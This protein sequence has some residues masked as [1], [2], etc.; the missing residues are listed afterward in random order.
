MMVSDEFVPIHDTEKTRGYAGVNFPMQAELFSQYQNAP[1][2][3][4]LNK[5]LANEFLRNSKSRR[6]RPGRTQFQE[7]LDLFL[8]SIVQTFWKQK[9]GID[10][11]ILEFASITRLQQCQDFL[12]SPLGQTL[13]TATGG[14]P[15]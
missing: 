7:S 2:T 14:R 4:L 5:Q 11:P 13:K 6:D 3:D 8:A 1:L 15:V 9:T 10:L 12:D